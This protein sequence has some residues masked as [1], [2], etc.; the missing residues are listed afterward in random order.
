[1][2]VPKRR[3]VA[4]FG[5]GLAAALIGS[6][7]A[8]ADP[9]VP[10]GGNAY[11]RPLHGEG[12]DTTDP[13]MNG[14]AEVLVDGGGNKLIASW[15]AKSADGF[16]T[17]SPANT[18]AGSNCTYGGNPTPD[19]AV[20]VEGRRANGSSNGQ[21][22]L[23]DAFNAGPAGPQETNGCLDFARSSSLPSAS[24]LGTLPVNAIPL[25]TDGLAFVRTSASLIPKQLTKAQLQAAYHCA[26]G[27]FKNNTNPA[28]ATNF[29]ALIPQAGSG[30][31]KD[32]LSVVGIT[33]TDL[34]NG[35]YPCVTDQ[36][37]LGPRRAAGDPASNPI[38]EHDS[39]AVNNFAVGP[40]SIAQWIAQKGGAI[41]DVQGAAVMGT[42]KATGADAAVSYP[43]QLSATFGNVGVPADNLA[44]T[45]TVYNVLPRSYM[46][47]GANP[48]ANA[49][50]AFADT[51]ADPAVNTSLICQREDVLKKFGLAPIASCGS[52]AFP[53]N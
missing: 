17:R 10:V 46:P 51:D 52:L 41:A 25:A 20:Y 19:N 40:V 36:A 53:V 1:M 14:L 26:F 27:N 37:D 12:S 39:R 2:K 13:V 21:K 7:V 4:A 8:N 16:T 15:D 3:L 30:T 44:A 33:E 24:N 50:L 5:I 42:I 35:L 38:Q 22:A 31:R 32:W 18:P 43:I 49:I 48:N 34:A 47:G 9:V 29:K 45:R 23:R 6:G 28:S 11:D